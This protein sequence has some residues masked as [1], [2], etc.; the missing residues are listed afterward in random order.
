MT[1]DWAKNDPSTL[2][3]GRRPQWMMTSMEDDFNGKQTQ[4]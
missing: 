4:Q 3:C 2:V 1:P